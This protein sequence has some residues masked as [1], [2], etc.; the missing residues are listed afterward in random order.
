MDLYIVDNKS[1]SYDLGVYSY[2]ES[3]EFLSPEGI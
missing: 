3:L 2:R 1:R